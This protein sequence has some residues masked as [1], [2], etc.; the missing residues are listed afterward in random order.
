MTVGGL[1]EPRGASRI[2]PAPHRVGRAFAV[3]QS[4]NPTSAFSVATGAGKA[5]VPQE[6]TAAEWVA[7]PGQVMSGLARK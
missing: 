1:G 7:A 3:R 2:G 5:G 4:S 6:V